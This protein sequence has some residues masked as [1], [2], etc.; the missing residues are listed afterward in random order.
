VDTLKRLL[1]VVIA[2]VQTLKLNPDKLQAALGEDMLA[3]DLADYLVKKGLP[4]RQ[5]HHVAGQAV[6]LAAEQNQRLSQLSLQTLQGLSPLFESDVASVFDFA[7]SVERR[8]APGGTAPEAVKAQI[9]AARKLLG[10]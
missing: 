10:E 9:A 6:R 4:F 3:T 2:V 8:K 1:P 5:A 7:A